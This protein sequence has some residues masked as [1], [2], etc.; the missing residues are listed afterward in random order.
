MDKIHISKFKDFAEVF[1]QKAGL[2]M[3]KNFSL[4]MTKTWK[5][6][7]TTPLTET[8]LAINSML[9]EEI[10]ANFPSHSVKAEEESNIQ[11]D[12][13]YMWVCD[14]VDGTIPFSHG[15]P[16]STF[17]LALVKNGE[18]IVGVVYDPFLD[19]LYSASKGGGAF[20]NGK[21]ISVSSTSVL[22]ATVGAYEHFETAKYNIS[23]IADQLTSKQAKMVRL[24]SIVY[25]TAL[26]AA[27]ELAF[28]IFPHTTAHDA[29]A[30][31]VIV[32]E[33]GGTFT[34]L[35]GNEQKYDRETNGFIA[36]NGLVHQE[37]VALVK[38]KFS[39]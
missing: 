12:A 29:A 1:A 32:K 28:S 6:E 18:S 27:G 10:K 30:V 17:S 33:A 24:C 11:K 13:E 4:G 31:C 25:P 26:V 20:L 9:I 15:I 19:R 2:I 36:S 39:N 38:S 23:S 34:D 35:F 14:P 7:D 21:Q 5:A 8:D 16:V 22:K 3:K 37:L